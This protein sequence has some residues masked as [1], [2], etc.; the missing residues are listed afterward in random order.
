[1]SFFWGAGTLILKKA[2]LVI[3]ILSGRGKLK[4][5]HWQCTGNKF[6][7]KGMS[8]NRRERLYWCD[9]CSWELRTEKWEM[10]SSY[11]L[12]LNKE[13]ALGRQGDNHK[14]DGN[15]CHKYPKQFYFIYDIRFLNQLMVELRDLEI[16]FRI[17]YRFRRHVIH[18]TRQQTPIAVSFKSTHF[19]KQCSRA[20]EESND[21]F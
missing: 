7:Q 16:F 3:G 2:F 6:L 12:H 4:L 20:Y 19:R 21:G 9:N 10:I 17:I 13:E 5:N 14:R 15:D 1:M 8:D 11:K 18:V